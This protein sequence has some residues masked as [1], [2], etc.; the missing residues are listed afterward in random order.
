MGYEVAGGVEVL[1]RKARKH[2]Y[3]HLGEDDT[4][5]FCIQGLAS[6]AII[7]LE[8]RLL[9]I[10]P[11]WE[12]GAS[13]GARVTSFHYRDITGI[14]VNTGLSMGVVE[15]NTPSYQ[16]GGTKDYWSTRP[17]HDPRRV[18]NC[19]PIYKRHL[20]KYKPHLAELERLIQETKE[21]H[22]TP[23]SGVSIG[24]ELEKLAGLRASG[25]LTDEEFQQA[26]SRLLG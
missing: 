17:D 3:K 25:V 15:I 18:S 7:A 19:I 5:R 22:R 2:L 20:A 10:K 13:F 21:D 23:T 24:S 16:G 14:E 11:G 1:A 26:K 8:D 12:A 9:V 4:V 6:Q